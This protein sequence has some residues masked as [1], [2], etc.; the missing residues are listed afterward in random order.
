MMSNIRLQIQRLT[1]LCIVII[2]KLLHFVPV[3][4]EVDD[5]VIQNPE[6]PRFRWLLQ[7]SRTLGQQQPM[8]NIVPSPT[9]HRLHKSHKFTANYALLINQE[10]ITSTHHQLNRN[11]QMQK[12]FILRLLIHINF[13]LALLVLVVLNVFV[14]VEEKL[15]ELLLVKYKK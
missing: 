4:F 15:Y 10:L 14:M 9:D 1:F 13:H 11:S 8:Q 12:P 6:Q 2:Q 3:T 7:L 5:T